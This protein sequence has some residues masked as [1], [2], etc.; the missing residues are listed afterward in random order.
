MVLWGT[1][2]Q[3]RCTISGCMASLCRYLYGRQHRW[4]YIHVRGSYSSRSC[5]CAC[6]FG[7]VRFFLSI[8]TRTISL[9]NATI[10]DGKIGRRGLFKEPISIFAMIWSFQSVLSCVRFWMWWEW[11]TVRRYSVR[12]HFFINFY[13][14]H[15]AKRVK[16]GPSFGALVSN[17]TQQF[18]A[19]HL[20]SVTNKCP[21][22]KDPLFM[23]QAAW[24]QL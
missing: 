11:C 1:W 9:P 17:T 7:W 8:D 20:E 4:L 24:V 5:L 13:S 19:T 10:I 14:L 12:D 16:Y 2:L 18:V 22:Q 3:P 21:N 15:W 23:F 6:L